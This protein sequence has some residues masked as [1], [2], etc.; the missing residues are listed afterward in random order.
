EIKEAIAVLNVTNVIQ[1]EAV[2]GLTVLHCTTEYPAPYEEVNLKAMGLLREEFN[3]EVGYSDHTQGIEVSVAAV[4]LGASVI[5]KH[6]TLDRRMEGPDHAASLEPDELKTMVQQIRNVELAL[7][8]ALKEPTTSELKNRDIA[9][10]S[11]VAKNEIKKCELFTEDNL[12]T[13]RPGTGISPMKWDELIGKRADRDFKK[14]E[15]IA[16]EYS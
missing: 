1:S 8:K 2:E 14:D 4:A 10:K 3:C 16:F 13:K 15:L 5:E 12:T 7:G 6:F 11:I 9:R